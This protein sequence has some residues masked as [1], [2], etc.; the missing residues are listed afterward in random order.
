MV[1]NAKDTHRLR[2]ISRTWHEVEG[3]ERSCIELHKVRQVMLVQLVLA[4]VGRVL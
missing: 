2:S 4:K 1:Q 3:L